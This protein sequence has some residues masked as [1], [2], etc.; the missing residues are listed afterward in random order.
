[1]RLIEMAPAVGVLIFIII[2][3]E[4]RNE[5]L[6]KTLVD[7]IEP[8]F[9]GGAPQKGRISAPVRPVRSQSA[10]EAH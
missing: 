4:Q 7:Y 1:M 10:S 3:Q 6:V 2:R 9:R 8:T 5:L